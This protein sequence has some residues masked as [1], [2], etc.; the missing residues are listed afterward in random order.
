MGSKEDGTR[1][2]RDHHCIYYYL[3]F[4]WHVLSKEIELE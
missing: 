2:F 1:M 4:T 3:L